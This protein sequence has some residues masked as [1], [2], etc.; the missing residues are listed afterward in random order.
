LFGCQTLCNVPYGDGA[1][2]GTRAP[3]SFSTLIVTVSHQPSTFAKVCSEVVGLRD[4]T[5]DYGN[6]AEGN[7]ENIL[8]PR[9]W[10]SAWGKSPWSHLH[11]NI[12][13]D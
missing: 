8:I 5:Q 11:A 6:L 12:H 13:N 4:A 9:W 10:Q 3:I 1:E 2:E 7:L